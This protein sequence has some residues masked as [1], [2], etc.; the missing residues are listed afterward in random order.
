MKYNILILLLNVAILSSADV[1]PFDVKALEFHGKEKVRVLRLVGKLAGDKAVRNLTYGFE[2]IDANKKVVRTDRMY[3]TKGKEGVLFDKG[4][5]GVICS[6]EVIDPLVVD[7][8]I[9]FEEVTY[10]DGSKWT[11]PE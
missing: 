6:I 11:M 8:K 4:F 9:W 5:D 2:L 1:E 3:S 7:G 10:V